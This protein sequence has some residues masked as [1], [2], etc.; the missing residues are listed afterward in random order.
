[1]LPYA[2]LEKYCSFIKQNGFQNFAV[3]MADMLDSMIKNERLNEPQV[4]K[5][6]LQT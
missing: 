4:V 2:E 5:A 1:M 6:E 3:R